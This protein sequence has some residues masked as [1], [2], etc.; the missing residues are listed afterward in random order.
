MLALAVAVMVFS[1]GHSTST[2]AQAQPPI[3]YNI[4]IPDAISCVGDKCD[5]LENTSFEVVASLDD[6]S[7]APNGAYDAMAV[8]ILYSDS[9][10]SDG[11]M[12][13]QADWPDCAFEATAYDDTTPGGKFENV[14][15]SIGIGAPSSTHLGD[16]ARG[17]WS[18]GTA[19]GSLTLEATTGASTLIIDDKGSTL[20]EGV[21]ETLN[22]NC[23]PPPPTPT[24]PP[25]ST[26]PPVPPMQKLPALQNE[27]LE[28]QGNK[29]PPTTCLMTDKGLPA[30]DVGELAETIPFVPVMPDPKDP[31]SDAELGA[32]E[33]QVH[34]DETKVC[35]V[36]TPKVGDVCIVEDATN[37]QLEGV[38]R[39][40]CVMLGKDDSISGPTPDPVV[41]ANISVYP[42]PDV[43]SQAKPNQDNG[44]VVQLNNVGCELAD[45]QGHPIPVFSCEDAD[46]TYRYLE[47]DV[48]ADCVVD[49][50]DTQ[51]IAFRWGAEKGS[52]IYTDFMNLEPSGTQADEDI[53]IKDL[54]FVFGRFGSTC[55]N[56]HPPQVPVNPKG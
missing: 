22:V 9:L 12:D 2:G 1:W 49:A 45:L 15:C 24:T 38:A 40:G 21:D 5:V 14:G 43:Y 28:R 25:T 42:Q 30:G 8:L 27:F 26:P 6:I 20:E 37:S 31:G 36:I 39:V 46:I 52:L 13:A 29:I 17:N 55:D 10:T 48:T 18:C 34:F 44:V 16:I 56:P 19:S 11:R 50:L 54:Q 32:F 3:D 35:V 53:D 47:G 7:G 33:F 4:S 51:S 23:V 41:L